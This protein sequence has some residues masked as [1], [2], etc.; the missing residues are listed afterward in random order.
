[1]KRAFAMAIFSFASLFSGP[2]HA[3]PES[4]FWRWFEKNDAQLFDF[5]ADQERVFDRL[6]AA[7]HKVDERLTF[8]FGP[9]VGNKREFVIS[10][11]GHRA[12]FPKVEALF[13]AAP[14]MPHWT[15]VKFRPRRTPMD[16]EY[17]GVAVK[18]EAVSV[19]VLVARSAD[20]VKLRVFIP[21]YTPARHNSYLGIAFLLLDQSLGEFDVETRVGPIDVLAPEAGNKDVY[22]LSELPAV[23]DNHFA[24]GD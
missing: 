6:A 4:E 21:G 10:A 5:E 7:M 2:A 8:E 20:K 3:S 11:D 15:F 16:I 19:S 22:S 9:K 12:A 1:M 14:V 17:G 18:A 13:A 23:L 24:R